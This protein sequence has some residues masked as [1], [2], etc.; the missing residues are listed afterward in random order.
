MEANSR[1]TIRLESTQIRCS[2]D[3]QVRGWTSPGVAK[4]AQSRKPRDLVGKICTMTAER[5]VQPAPS[6][7]RKRREMKLKMK[8]MMMW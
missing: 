6:Q 1:W 5:K 4:E 2:R 3:G 7:G 8:M